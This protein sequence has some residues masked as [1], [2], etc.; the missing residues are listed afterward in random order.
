MKLPRSRTS[1]RRNNGNSNGNNSSRRSKRK[2]VLVIDL[3]IAKDIV[4]QACI[5]AINADPLDL[6]D[7]DDETTDAH[8]NHHVET[9]EF[10]EF[11]S[12]T[13]ARAIASA[14]AKAK[15]TV[16]V[17]PL[18]PGAQTRTTTKKRRRPRKRP[19]KLESR[20]EGLEH[21]E[22]LHTMCSLF[23]VLHD[24]GVV[25]PMP[26]PMPM[27]TTND[28]NHPSSE[29]GAT[30]DHDGVCDDR[31]SLS[32]DL[33]SEESNSNHSDHASL[34]PPVGAASAT[35]TP[36]R[37]T[38]D[39]TTTCRREKIAAVSIK[40][41]PQT[42]PLKQQQHSTTTQAPS[43]PLAIT[44]SYTENGS[45]SM[46]ALT[47]TPTECDY[48]YPL[49]GVVG[50]EGSGIA[51]HLSLKTNGRGNFYG[52]NNNGDNTNDVIICL[53]KVGSIVRQKTPPLD[54]AKR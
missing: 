54:A 48:D 11:V 47:R 51:S 39:R 49:I 28:A 42:P 2:K 33:C 14:V 21:S 17:Q 44:T 30:G 20:V 37:P 31:E 46:L 25:V 38:T 34:L 5:A 4:E 10:T 12:S 22:S 53:T 13:I 24:S 41:T 23:P 1:R 19:R 29:N 40:S 43:P 8:C 7:K 6:D 9:T 52:R 35:T 3:D 36:T 32:S 16:K 45:N 18:S 27:A 50:D 15:A 26:M